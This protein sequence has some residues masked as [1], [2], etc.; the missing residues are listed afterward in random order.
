[1]KIVFVYAGNESLGLE[2]L[3]AVLK[4]HGHETD[5]VFDPMIFS[6]A[7][8][9]ATRLR[10]LLDCET[11]V[12]ERV[13][14]SG[15]DLVAFSVVTDYYEWALR[16]ARLIKAR[17]DAPIIFGGIHPTS[18]PEQVIEENAV[19]IVCI[20]EGEGALLD[21]ANQLDRNGTYAP[22]TPIENLWIKSGTNT[23]RGEI[24]PL[25]A[26]LDELPFADKSLFYRR[27]PVFSKQYTIMMSRGCPFKCSFCCNNLLRTLSRGK[28]KYLRWRSVENVIEE[29]VQAKRRWNYRSVAFYDDVFTFNKTWARAFLPLYRKEIHRPFA[30]VEHPSMVD[31]EI[32]ALL[33][34][35]GCVNIQLGVQSLNERSRR[36][37]LGRTE[38]N[39][40][41]RDTLEL[42]RKYAIGVTVDHIAEIPYEAEADQVGAVRFYNEVRP[43]VINFFWLS[44]YPKTE[45]CRFHDGTSRSERGLRSLIIR[46]RRT[47]RKSP[48]AA[49]E[50]FLNLLPLMPRWT[51]DFFLRKKRYKLLSLFPTT[52]AVILP[53]LVSIVRSK[54]I[55]S[56]A[57]LARVTRLFPYALKLRVQSL[58][59]TEKARG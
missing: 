26:S 46:D 27:V 17:C 34:E 19:D 15:A 18:V 14:S 42:I 21:L 12:I 47:K 25:V 9:S 39:E 56:G 28:G 11:S 58:F 1:M 23:I 48:F 7:Y 37:V 4:Q 32:V 51:V 13:V 20:G 45:I 30:C 6:D 2:I 43:N 59:R 41:I 44:Y 29:L 5:L 55:R 10:R 24:R 50:A 31:E 49:F 35:A 40:E 8:L 57:H 3:S 38:T 22:Q 36:D 33:K 16:F 52:L 53:R 54:D